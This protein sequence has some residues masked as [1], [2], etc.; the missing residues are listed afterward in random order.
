LETEDTPTAT[1]TGA[2]KRRKPTVS[3]KTT[4]RK[5]TLSQSTEETTESES[6][7]KQST[8]EAETDAKEDVVP[9]LRRSS[10]QVVI[11]KTVSATVVETQ[12]SLDTPSKDAVAATPGF[13][14]YT[15]F[16]ALSKAQLQQE[17]NVT[18]TLQR[19]VPD[20]TRG[21]D[22]KKRGTRKMESVPEVETNTNEED[23][24]KETAQDSLPAS[25][26]LPKSTRIRFDSEE[27]AD[28]TTASDQL[29]AEDQSAPAVNTPQDEEEEEEND[30]DDEAP[31]EV[32][33]A[34]ALS[35]A[36]AAEAEAARAA[37]AQQEKQELKRK[38]RA[39]RIAEEQKQKRERLAEEE[40][41]KREKEERRAKKLAKREARNQA[42]PEAQSF[43]VDMHNLPAL[44][45]DS[46][47]EAVGDQRPPTPPRFLPGVSAEEKRKEKLQRHIKFLE[48]GEK[49]IKDVK[50]GSL[51]VRV[52]EQQNALLGPK[53]NKDT[54]NVREKWLKGREVEK[55]KKGK[56]L[57]FKK[58]ER[59][60]VGGGFLRGG[61]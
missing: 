7:T 61:D 52:L 28:I 3:K 47:L 18:P 8:P 2:N 33:T 17:A 36:K 56:N 42:K 14:P 30:S 27:A 53:M 15:P 37:K 48:R 9:T 32:T 45:P 34:S 1:P 49:P 24:Q 54:R 22:K 19:A 60:P 59:R 44:L 29:H 57:K 50:K 4:P 40:R 20:R 35:K 31:E 38:E 13:E 39:E 5:S 25:E 58:V 21:S 23:D 46:L 41:Q 16:T 12:D 26:T 55:Q 10:P 43:D 6:V 51:N 11:Q